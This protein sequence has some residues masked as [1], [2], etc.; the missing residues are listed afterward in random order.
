MVGWEAGPGM[1]DLMELANIIG[2]YWEHE[3][4]TSKN[5]GLM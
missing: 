4:F 3:S 5:W 2:K 1:G